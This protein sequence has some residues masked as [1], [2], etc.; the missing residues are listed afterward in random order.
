MPLVDTKCYNLFIERNCQ[1][2]F[3]TQGGLSY[4]IS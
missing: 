4:A 2:K 3:I 1:E